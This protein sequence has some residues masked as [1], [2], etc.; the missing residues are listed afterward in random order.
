[1][2]M[3]VETTDNRFFR[4][5]EDN[6]PALSHL[7]IGVPVK[8]SKGTWVPRANAKQT[9]VRKEGS[10]IVGAPNSWA[11]EVLVEGK[12]SRNSIRFATQREAAADASGLMWRWTAVRD[13]RATP[14]DEAPNSVFAD[15]R[16]VFTPA[17]EG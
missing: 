6:D 15:G 13:S 9:L 4:V 5:R 16:S 1:M 2:T 14:A 8:R 17:Q 10:R 11:P 3:I 12:W 7:W